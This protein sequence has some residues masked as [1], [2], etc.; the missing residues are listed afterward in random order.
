M[1]TSETPLS[2]NTIF[3]SIS[4]PLINSTGIGTGMHRKCSRP[5]NPAGSDW[6]DTGNGY[7]K[8]G[9]LTNFVAISFLPV[10]HYQ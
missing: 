9:Y 1:P 7:R 2:I 8:N 6:P 3:D 5:D 10:F 4:K